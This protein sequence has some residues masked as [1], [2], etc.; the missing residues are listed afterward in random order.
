MR[1]LSAKQSLVSVIIPTFNSERFLEKCLSSLKRQTYE[2]LE[3]IVV[4]DGSTDSTIGIAERQG[5]K[6]I[7]NPKVGRAAAKNEGVRHSFGEYLVF[8]DS[9]MELTPNV[10]SECVDLA[11]SDSHVGGVVIP[12]RSVGNSFW[13]KVRD[14]ER[15]FY[16][17]SVVESARFF[18]TKLV[19]EVGGY[20]ENLIF[21][22]ESTLPYKI[23]KK[24][25][26]VF[27]RV[28]SVILHREENFSLITWLR[29]KSY[30]GKTIH[31]YEHKYRDYSR[32]QTSAGFRFYLF[33]KSYRR[34]LSRPEL[35]LG[36]IVLKSL[37]YLAVV[38]GARALVGMK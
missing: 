9:D 26:N 13:V 6:I 19:K 30:Y 2:R 14:F 15:S 23:Q 7:K 11:E 38:S 3:I 22:E 16:A 12:E 33:V 4:D 17:G 28:N 1:K 25:N 35:A 8:V 21:F 34:F 18:P 5:C 10:L 24:G 20:E 29:K 36:V 27:A 32:M 31:V 37:E